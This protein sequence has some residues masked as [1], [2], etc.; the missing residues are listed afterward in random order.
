MKCLRCEQESKTGELVFPV[1]QTRSDGASPKS[2]QWPSGFVH[3]VCGA[4]K[5]V[6][7]DGPDA[8]YLRGGSEAAFKYVQEMADD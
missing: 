8:Q 7:Y 3:V 1:Y 4:G 6:E 5:I 2:S